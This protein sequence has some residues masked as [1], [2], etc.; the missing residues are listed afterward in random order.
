MQVITTLRSKNILYYFIAF[1]QQSY[2]VST[3]LLYPYYS[4]RELDILNEMS[5]VPED[6]NSKAIY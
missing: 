5:K 1:F 4:Y 6:I 2:D 3:M